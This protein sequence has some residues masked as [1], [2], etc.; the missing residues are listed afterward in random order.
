MV[1]Q[2]GI[3]GCGG[4]ARSH[5]NAYMANNVK[6]VAVTD[7]NPDAAN[8]LA[9]DIGATVCRD[10]SSLIE[11]EDVRMV[12]ICT[13]PAVH[14]EAAIHALRHG[15]HAL[16]EKPLANDLEA[17]NRIRQAAHESDALLMPAFRHRF[18]PAIVAVRDLLRGGVI[19]DVVF[20]NNTFCGPM[21]YMEDRWFTR[22]AVAGGGCLIDTSSHSVDLFRYLVG[23]IVQQHA[24][25]HRHLKTTDVEDAGILS[26]KAATGAIGS[27]QSSF[28]AG[29]GLA[30]LDI[31]GTKGRLTYDYT[32]PDR[33]RHRT[34]SDDQWQILRVPVSSGFKEEIAHLVGAIQGHHELACTVEDGWQALSVICDAYR[35]QPRQTGTRISRRP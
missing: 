27:L 25:M 34:T 23:D 20:F 30:I 1:V 4:V 14:E 8:A 12:S 32:E 11:R 13:P 7:S 19:G 28:V 26:L 6:V 18:M 2:A 33:I 24:V 31:V 3:I 21:F 16:C 35:R 17:G 29:T 22:K 10:F 15:V 5:L 9:A